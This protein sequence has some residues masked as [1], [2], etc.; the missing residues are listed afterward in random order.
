VAVIATLALC[1]FAAYTL[2]PVQAVGFS[3]YQNTAPPLAA[4]AGGVTLAV[5]HSRYLTLDTITVTLTNASGA[6][7]Y[8]PDVEE[9][10]VS[11]VS[12]GR[13]C[14]LS[15]V[16]YQSAHG[17][18]AVGGCGLSAGYCHGGHGDAAPPLP[19][20]GWGVVGPGETIILDNYVGQ[21]SHP[22]L[23]PGAYRFGVGYSPTPSQ[24]TPDL[25]ILR[26][27]AGVSGSDVFWLQTP[28]VTLTSAWWIPPWYHWHL[29]CAGSFPL[30]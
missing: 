17:W 1:A 27:L 3:T 20:A 22:P 2:G 8:V 30:S 15:S 29:F 19:T 13:I 12:V 28:P 9:M 24:H 21:D 6:T 11:G 5:E 4:S 25:D 26:A 18:Q 10:T 23:S 7:I 14:W 16:E